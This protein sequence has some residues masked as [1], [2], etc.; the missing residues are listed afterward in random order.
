ME[1]FAS[2]SRGSIVIVYLAQCRGPY[3][4]PRRSRG[5]AKGGC[6]RE[7]AQ[8]EGCWI[9]SG[10][11]RSRSTAAT[12]PANAIRVGLA[13]PGSFGPA[14]AR[15]PVSTA[16]LHY[17]EATGGWCSRDV[18]DRCHSPDVTDRSHSQG[19]TVHSHQGATDRFH[20]REA[21]AG[22]RYPEEWVD[23]ARVDPRVAADVGAVEAVAADWVA[24]A[25]SAGSVAA[26]DEAAAAC[27]SNSSADRTTADLCNN[28]PS[29]RRY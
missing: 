27:A 5:C 14:T 22:S 20:F 23:R 6:T 16:V 21:T 12:R 17:P 19:V 28:G 8:R 2:V 1:L 29:N 18:T 26:D 15:Y 25:D 3:A 10:K 7:A 13:S 11:R 9:L 4:I 24:A